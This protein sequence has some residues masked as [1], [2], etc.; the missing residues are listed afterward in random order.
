MSFIYVSKIGPGD[1]QPPQMFE[2]N[3]KTYAV[4]LYK[5]HRVHL[6][7][8]I[9]LHNH[10]DNTFIRTI[11]IKQCKAKDERKEDDRGQKLG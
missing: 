5:V 10:Y 2:Y 4:L 11:I 1:V 7:Q 8:Y 9:H 6:S 3:H